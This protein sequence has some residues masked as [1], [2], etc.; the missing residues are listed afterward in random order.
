VRHL[1]VIEE[2]AGEPNSA[3][4]VTQRNISPP[5]TFSAAYLFPEFLG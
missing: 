5:A 3:A 1:K 2:T 4:G